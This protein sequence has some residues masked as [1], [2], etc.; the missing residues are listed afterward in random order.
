MH[1]PIDTNTMSV[2]QDFPNA[3]WSVCCAEAKTDAE[4]NTTDSFHDTCPGGGSSVIGL[5]YEPDVTNVEH[6][7]KEGASSQMMSGGKSV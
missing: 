7:D 6:P 3:I 5:Y 1:I 2:K 4:G